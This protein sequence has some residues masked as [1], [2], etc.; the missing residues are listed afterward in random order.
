MLLLL[1]TFCTMLIMLRIN[2][3]GSIN[4]NR[5]VSCS[6][7]TQ[8]QNKTRTFLLFQRTRLVAQLQRCWNFIARY[9]LERSHLDPSRT[10]FEYFISFPTIECSLDIESDNARNFM[11]R[12]KIDFIFSRI[13]GSSIE[14][15]LKLFLV[16]KRGDWGRWPRSCAE[17]IFGRECIISVAV[18]HHSQ[19]RIPRLMSSSAAFF[20]IYDS[21]AITELFFYV[22]V[23]KLWAYLV[24][25]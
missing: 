2:D 10:W 11:V 23:D 22:R 4:W 5:L 1:T 18:L 14:W 16:L 6:K 21:N 20:M 8:L 9:Y 15:L 24:V 12:I 19:S 7:F 25:S 13:L 3:K 17:M